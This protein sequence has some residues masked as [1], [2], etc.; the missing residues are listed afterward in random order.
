MSQIQ[1]SVEVCDELFTCNKYMFVDFVIISI[2]L[3]FK[4]KCP[5]IGSRPSFSMLTIKH[6]ITKFV[7]PSHIRIRFNL[8]LKIAKLLSVFV[9]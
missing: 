4:Q 1:K 3:N 8:K 5:S 2:F 6:Q 7:S 9:V